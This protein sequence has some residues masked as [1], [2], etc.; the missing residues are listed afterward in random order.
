MKIIYIIFKQKSKIMKKFLLALV[1]VLFSISAFAQTRLYVNPAFSQKTRNHKEIAVLPFQVTLR[2]RPKQ[3]RNITPQQL[4][5]MEYAQG[6]GIQSAMFS[7][8]LARGKKGKLKVRIQD[9]MTTNAIFKKNG[10]TIKN[11]TEYTPKELANFLG[12][13]AIVMGTM[14]TNKPLSTGASIAL[15]VITGFYGMTNKATM[16]LFIY[17]G[18][19]GDVLVNYH[20]AVAGSLGSTVESMVNILMR[21]ASRRIPYF[22]R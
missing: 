3:M 18:K 12:V 16:N 6:K 14:E 2:L 4:K 11:I 9:P 5:N 19:D 7:W 13:D 15:G 10:I 20:K 1:V 22:K 21:K 17:N 8:F